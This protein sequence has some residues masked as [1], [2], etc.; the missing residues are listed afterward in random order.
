MQVRKKVINDKYLNRQTT[1]MHT[2]IQ[3]LTLQVLKQ[4]KRSIKS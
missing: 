2:K 3:F 1:K 4:N